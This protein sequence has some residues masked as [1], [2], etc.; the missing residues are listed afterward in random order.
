MS[1]KK[2]E[3]F[4]VGLVSV[5]NVKEELT[6]AGGLSSLVNAS[7]KNGNV[8]ALAPFD[9]VITLAVDETPIGLLRDAFSEGYFVA[10]AKVGDS[11]ADLVYI[12]DS[13]ARTLL[14]NNCYQPTS[15]VCMVIMNN[16]LFTCDGKRTPIVMKIDDP[17]VRVNLTTG[18]TP[19]R[20]AFPSPW[21]TNQ[22]RY[23]VVYA[24]RIWT[25]L[26][27]S[28]QLWHSTL[29]DG[30]DWTIASGTPADS[31]NVYTVGESNIPI[32]SLVVGLFGLTIIK[33]KGLFFIKSSGN[34]Y[35]ANDFSLGVSYSS[36][37]TQTPWTACSLLD[38]VI[39]VGKFG[40]QAISLDQ[41]TGSV[42]VDNLGSNWRAFLQTGYSDVSE[43]NS[44]SVSQ[45]M[46]TLYMDCF[47][48]GL[49]GYSRGFYGFRL[50]PEG[51]VDV[52]LADELSY[53]GEAYSGTAGSLRMLFRRKNEIWAWRGT[54]GYPD[55][56]MY[57]AMST[58]LTP[59][60]GNDSVVKLTHIKVNGIFP[61]GAELSY[62]VDGSTESIDNVKVQAITTSTNN[63]AIF[64]STQP[65]TLGYFNN[66]GDF[67][68]TKNI[69]NTT[70]SIATIRAFGN[71]QKIR[72]TVVLPDTKS[73]GILKSIIVE[74]AAGGFVKN[75]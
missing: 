66:S 23:A 19:S 61:N 38:K 3:D 47:V 57:T 50:D 11:L 22:P 55:P 8:Q 48:K 72:L 41:R 27:G 33:Q 31:A 7:V 64:N 56:S 46:T 68:F 26:S 35:D 2:W 62:S 75:G 37:S 51:V 54:Q 65:N 59:L 74:Y 14:V 17:L 52:C 45:D 73:Y 30:S 42:V 5:D 15:R 70:E 49:T 1:Y 53:I 24:N 34:I 6:P 67:V 63:G 36:I 43:F 58:T 12:A 25:T 29:D 28:N 32:V 60:T 16:K 39:T 9:K 44:I 40:I 10:V 69:G 20:P 21:T 71:A 13:G 4:S 18:S